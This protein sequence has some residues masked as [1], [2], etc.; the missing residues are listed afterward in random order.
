MKIPV[1]LKTEYLIFEMFMLFSVLA[2][3]CMML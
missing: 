2:I 3:V 1:F